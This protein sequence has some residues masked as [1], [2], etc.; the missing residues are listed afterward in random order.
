M[1]VGYI[2]GGVSLLA[3]GSYVVASIVLFKFPHL[4]H[5]RKEPKFRAVHISHRGGAADKIENTMEAFQ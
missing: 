5:K 4:I 2:V 3:F 1:S